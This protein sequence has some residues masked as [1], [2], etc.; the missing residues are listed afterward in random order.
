M[1]PDNASVE[2]SD[3]SVEASS[4][5]GSSV[6]RGTGSKSKSCMISSSTSTSSTTFSVPFV[7]SSSISS[8]VPS[9]IKEVGSSVA[10]DSVGASSL[11]SSSVRAVS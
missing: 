8:T 2:T 4:L 11:V 7:N 5:V 6:P 9:V 10:D 3:D 1:L